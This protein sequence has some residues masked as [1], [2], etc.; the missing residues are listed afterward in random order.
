MNINKYLIKSFISKN[1]I[2]ISCLLYALLFQIIFSEPQQSS[3]GNYIKSFELK[4]G[5][6]I[7]MFTEKG[8]YLCNK[9]TRN[10]EWK[11]TFAND[12]SQQ[13]FDLLTIKQFDF[14]RYCIIALYKDMIYIFTEEGKLFIEQSVSFDNNNGK[15]FTLVPYKLEIKEDN[16]ND[17][18]FIVGYL[19]ESTQFIINFFVFNNLSPNITKFDDI[20]LS[21]TNCSSIY[22]H[23]GFSCQLMNSESY[24]QVLT[25]FFHN[26]DKL[27]IESYN[28]TDFKPISS[29]SYKLEDINPYLIYSVASKNKNQSLICYLKNWNSARCDKYDIN[30]NSLSNLYEETEKQCNHQNHLMSMIYTSIQEN[31]FIYACTGYDSDYNFYQFNSNFELEKVVNNGQFKI[32]N[33]DA[34]VISLIESLTEE[35]KLNLITSCKG[36]GVILN[37]VPNIMQQNNFSPLQSQSP[38]PTPPP[39]SSLPTTSLPITSVPSTSLPTTP[40]PATYKNELVDTTNL[41]KEKTYLTTFEEET[42]NVN[43]PPNK[44]DST[45]MVI[46]T[47]IINIDTKE[48]SAKIFT[49]DFYSTLI[50]DITTETSKNEACPEEYPYQHAE[51]KECLKSCS[52]DDLRNKKCKLNSISNSNINTFTENIRNLIKEKNLT[53]SDTNII[54][55]GSNT[56]Y[57]VISSN[58]MQENENTNISIIDLGECEKILLDEYNLSYLLILKIDSKINENTAVVL[59]YEVYNPYTTEKLNLSLCRNIKINTYSTHYP[60]EESKSKI[61]QLN[62][63]GYDLYN[64]NDNFYQDICSPFT[65]ENG[66]DILLSDRKSDFYENISLCENNCTYKGYDLDKNRVQCECSIK[67]EIKVEESS[68]NDNIFENLFSAS[69]FSNIKLLK[70]FKLVFSAKG[71]KNNKGSIIFLS[72]NF[73]IFISSII[74]A[75]NH[76]RYILRN[77]SKVN[78]EKYKDSK[79]KNDIIN[80]LNGKSK[81]HLVFPPKETKK[82][83]KKQNK[84][85]KK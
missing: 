61:K 51:T 8:I 83:T 6:Y 62:E 49:D 35:N 64:I 48:I 7:L 65:S 77:I 82:K 75:I 52:T 69:T 28:L 33:C 4:D 50:I 42:T 40:T 56:T 24:G 1:S 13:D 5:N 63:L 44:I 21:I 85:K 81:T 31:E 16:S 2:F 79:P 58:K 32:N 38:N 43:Q 59:N 27:N 15:Y 80:N 67:E 84:S 47:Y 25:C 10:I 11:K 55:E 71:Q 30:E 78:N 45:Q 53:S 68:N 37:D 74:Y 70:C 39:T 29:L 23:A 14:G 9:I 66:T 54:L 20:S 12:I 3:D 17:Y 60:S 34:V 46:P 18:Y 36:E 57:Q 41:S 22:S 19:K 76:E 73:V 72:I 26:N